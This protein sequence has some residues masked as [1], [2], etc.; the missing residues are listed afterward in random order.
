ME[1]QTITKENLYPVSYDINRVF[2]QVITAFLMAVGGHTLHHLGLTF[3]G[4]VVISV[5]VSVALY[6][7]YIILKLKQ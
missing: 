1:N 7:L 3:L 5:A 6:N 2:V 4:C